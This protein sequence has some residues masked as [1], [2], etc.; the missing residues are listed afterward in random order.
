MDLLTL[1]E[2]TV[3]NINE[4]FTIHFNNE[5]KSLTPIIFYYFKS[6]IKNIL[7]SSI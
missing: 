5:D 7:I 3:S 4:L 6:I 2:N 1:K